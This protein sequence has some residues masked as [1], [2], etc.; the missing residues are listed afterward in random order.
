M[1]KPNFA[2]FY[3]SL[4]GYTPF[5]WQ[6]RLADRAASGHWPDALNLPTSSGKTAVLDVWLWAH[7][8]GI[9]NTP[10]RLY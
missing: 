10:K 3:K 6:V 9:P 5:P 1:N 8:V 7:S 2:D 4:H